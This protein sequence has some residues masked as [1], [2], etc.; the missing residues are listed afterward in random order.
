MK[1]FVSLL[2]AVCTCLSVGVMITSCSDENN[3]TVSSSE[4]SFNSADG[5]NDSEQGNSFVGEED[6]KAPNIPPSDGLEFTLS[7]DEMSYIVTGTGICIDTDIVIPSTYNNLPV[8]KI[9]YGAFEEFT[10]MT[11]VVIPDSVLT[12]GT[13]A[14]RKCSSLTSVFLGASVV[15]IEDMAFY[16]CYKLESINIPASVKRIG[17]S[18]FDECGR[19]IYS[20]YEGGKYLGS[21][22]NPY[23]VLISVSDRTRTTY[24]INENTSILYADVF[25][26]CENMVTIA[27]PNSIVF[28]GASA[29]RRCPRLVSVTLGEKLETIG[30]SAFYYCE[31][32]K[33]INFPNSLKNIGNSAFYYCTKLSNVSFGASLET[34][35]ESAFQFCYLLESVTFP[36]SVKEIGKYAFNDCTNLKNVETL[37]P[38]TI[39]G[40]GF[41]SCPIET[42]SVPAD[43]ISSIS[44]KNLIS[45]NVISGDKIEECAFS[46]GF[47]WCENLRKVTIA[48]SVTTIARNAFQGCINLTNITV[49]EKNENYKS[50]DGNLY[51]KDGKTLIRYAIGKTDTNFSIPTGV[52][53]IAAQAFYNA[54]NLINVEIADTVLSIGDNAFQEC[55]NL[56]SVIIGKSVTEIGSEAFRWCESLITFTFNGTIN[57]WKSITKGKYWRSTN[58]Y[59][60][61]PAEYVICSDSVIDL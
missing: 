48:E 37:N 30:S 25:A 8:T 9:G 2:L 32:L 4:E 35:G 20:D 19:L 22:S 31:E 60:Y 53:A 54:K 13:D 17:Y 36:L 46:C 3:G 29:F 58:N 16:K 56:E 61:I 28:I 12:I 39:I 45:I 42:A 43:I 23:R 5:G 10:A 18:A 21:N 27:L 38:N 40:A 34:I 6:E 47:G 59:Y 1:K 26:G 44:N 14:F 33:N 50:I 15:S 11:S 55:S 7:D 49:D 24:T 57:E 52:T 41:S 51:T